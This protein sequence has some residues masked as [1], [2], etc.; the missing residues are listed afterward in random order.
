VNVTKV[1]KRYLLADGH[2]RVAALRL[3]KKDAILAHINGPETAKV[4]R[5]INHN[6]KPHTATQKLASFLVNEETAPQ[7]VRT[8][9]T[10]MIKKIGRKMAKKMVENNFNFGSYCRAGHVANY[11]GMDVKTVLNY[12]MD[13]KQTYALRVAMREGWTP[14]ELRSKIESGKTLF[15]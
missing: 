5:H 10:N 7:N 11:V 8:S 2:R 13:T 6:S 1:G 12:M 9:L 15:A 3:L 4:Y 14:K